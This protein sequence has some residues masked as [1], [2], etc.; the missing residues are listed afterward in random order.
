MPAHPALLFIFRCLLACSAA[1][2]LAACGASAPQVTLT[3]AYGQ[4]QSQLAELRT[5]ATVSRARMQTTLDYADA[6]VSEVEEAR[7]F[8]RFSLIN[9]GTDSDFLATSIR[10]LEGISIETA[11]PQP[12]RVGAANADAS[13]PPVIVTAAAPVEITPPVSPSPDA[14][15]RLENIVLA[16]GVDDRDCAIN[17]NPLFTEASPVIYVVGEAYNVPAG[18]TISSSWQRQG[19]EVAAF[20]FQAA[21]AINGNCIWFFID[22]TDTAFLEGLWSVSLFVDDAPVSEPVVFQVYPP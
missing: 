21:R 7:E 15:P 14:L 4:A 16:T 17:S 12:S 18:A 20:S 19:S 22:Q 1:S 9:L 13:R 5:R 3:A 10:E 2:A 6:R 11:L 8:L